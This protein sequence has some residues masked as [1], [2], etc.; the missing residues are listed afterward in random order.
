MLSRYATEDMMLKSVVSIYTGI[1]RYFWQN[2]TFALVLLVQ[3]VYVFQCVCVFSFF[4][5]IRLVLE[6]IFAQYTRMNMNEWSYSFLLLYKRYVSS[7]RVHNSLIHFIYIK[8]HE[9]KRSLL[10]FFFQAFSPV[11]LAF[12]FSIV[13]G[14]FSLLLF[15]SF[16]PILCV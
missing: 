1:C 14:F 10:F 7:Y 4:I 6:N 9:G 16:K 15:I 12:Q 13:L 5:L 3:K 8:T 2:N 11:C